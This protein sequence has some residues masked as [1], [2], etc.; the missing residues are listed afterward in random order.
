MMRHNLLVLALAI[1]LNQAACGADNS[2]TS[3]TPPVPPTE[4]SPKQADSMKIR[5]R[6]EDTANTATL[7]ESKT[8]QDFIS[9]LPITL[10]MNDLFG[11]EKYGHLP[12]ELPTATTIEAL[13]SA[14]SIAETPKEVMF[15]TPTEKNRTFSC[16]FP[17]YLASFF[18]R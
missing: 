17:N 10:T 11:R 6:I 3:G 16:E 8:T 7:I 5:L 15:Y 1:G 2:T 12:R 18:P 14:S 9:L 4:I 13:S